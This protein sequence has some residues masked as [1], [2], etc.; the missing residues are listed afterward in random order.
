[1]NLI[2]CDFD[3]TVSKEDTVKKFLNTFASEKWLDVEKLWEDG[4]IG[5][6]ECLLRQIELVR[7]IAEDELEDFLLSLEI[8]ETF[9]E[10]YDYIKSM[11]TKLIIL[12]DGFDLFIK[13]TLEKYGISDIEFYSN[14]LVYKD[15]RLKV[16]FLNSD[17]NCIRHSGMCKCSKITQQDFYYIGD[18]LSDVCIAK[19]ARTSFAKH[20]LRKYFDEN[21][22]AYIPFESFKD[23]TDYFV[24][25]GGTN[26]EAFRFNLR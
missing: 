5:S 22:I 19:K 7:E 21:K 3:G 4:A 14:S 24:Y 23:I 1:M 18:G 12:S 2:Y 17:I 20:N 11:N 10:F 8:D 25:K 16:Q 6:K 9:C 26:A 15:K 13:R